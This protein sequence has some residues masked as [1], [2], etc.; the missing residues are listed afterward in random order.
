M[1]TQLIIPTS[2]AAVIHLGLLFGF[3]NKPDAQGSMVVGEP[4]LPCS[5][6][7]ELLP[8]PLPFTETEP[9]PIDTSKNVSRV[10][11]LEPKGTKIEARSFAVVTPCPISMDKSQIQVLGGPLQIDA[12]EWGNGLG[13]ISG[14]AIGVAG[15]DSPAQATYQK[16]PIYPHQLR[17]EGIQGVV[18][19]SFVVDTNGRVET[20][21]ATKFSQREF[22]REAES[23]VRTW[24]FKPG[25]KNG[26]PVKFKMSVPI[27]FSISDN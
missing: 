1:K 17:R 8:P 9:E 11:G 26:R 24:R 14:S 13:T 27:V 12:G 2:A 6:P 15:L 4:P 23:A 10:E 25:T 19:V 21:K 20:A 18:E 3:N 22:A 16:S 5:Y 7:V